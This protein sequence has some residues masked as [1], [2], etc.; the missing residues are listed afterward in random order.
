MLKVEQLRI[1]FKGKKKSENE[2]VHGISFDVGQGEIVG[3][4]GESGSGK[5]VTALGIMGLL[6]DSGAV[7]GGSIVFDGAQ[8]LEMDKKK[9]S[10]IKGKE[11]CMIFQEPLTSLNPTMKIGR[12]VE[13]VL[14]LHTD[15][16]KEMRRQKILEALEAVGLKN[17]ERVCG[18]YP[19]QLSGG[20]RQ[21]VMIAMAVM[22]Q[23]KLMIADEPTTALDVT[24]QRQILDLIMEISR[25][26][27]TA[28]LF[29]THDL[30]LARKYCNRVVVMK[31]G[32]IVEHGTAKEVFDSPKEEYTKKLV[33]AVL[34]RRRKGDCYE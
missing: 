32:N 17:P 9:A 19:H 6:G 25:K 22:M 27:N 31:D 15:L 12:Q 18:I 5:S 8:I 24:T 7:T 16:D 14:L 23:P 11:L 33:G 3:M 28:V 1:A 34:D 10:Q 13:E 21:R 2:V 30:K 26:Q 4:V 29:I 20:M